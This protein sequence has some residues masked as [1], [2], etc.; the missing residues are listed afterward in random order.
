M[1]NRRSETPPVYEDYVLPL[2][3]KGKKI[4]I[5]SDD[6]TYEAAG[7]KCAEILAEKYRVSSLVL[8]SGRG[9]RVC[10]EEKYLAAISDRLKGKDAIITVGAGSVTDLGKFVA[11]SLAKSFANAD[12]RISSMVTGEDF[13]LLPYFLVTRAE[14][15]YIDKGKELISRGEKSIRYLMDGFNI[16]GPSMVI[17]GVSADPVEPDK[18]RSIR[19]NRPFRKDKQGT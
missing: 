13:C 18:E 11:D 2:L 5:F 6:N 9:K 19:S 10:A 17:A 15:R 16:G 14:D 8:S 7:R 4:L 1:K 12:W 3:I